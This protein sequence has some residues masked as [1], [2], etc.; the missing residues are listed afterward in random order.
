M[1]SPFFTPI[2][3]EEPPIYGRSLALL[4]EPHSYRAENVFVMK[5]LK[6]PCCIFRYELIPGKQGLFSL[7]AI[8]ALS[9]LFQ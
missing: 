2:K 1:I 4:R 7:R 3:V 5:T 8:V 9:G 6:F